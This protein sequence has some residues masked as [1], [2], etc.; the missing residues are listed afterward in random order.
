MKCFQFGFVFFY[1]GFTGVCCKTYITLAQIE[2]GVHEKHLNKVKRSDGDNGREINPSCS[3]N[4][5]SKQ[6]QIRPHNLLQNRAEVSPPA[7]F[8]RR[9]PS[10]DAV[11]DDEEVVDLEKR[12]DDGNDGVHRCCFLASVTYKSLESRLKFSCFRSLSGN[13][14]L[15]LLSAPQK[16]VRAVERFLNSLVGGL[17]QVGLHLFQG[18]GSRAS[19]RANV[20][21]EG[22]RMLA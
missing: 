4:E 5:A 11:D 7:L 12:I 22:A 2:K 16:D 14:L 8:F 13:T 1:Y 21:D 6:V 18:V 10:G 9:N 19:G 15:C 3:R 17:F 20:L